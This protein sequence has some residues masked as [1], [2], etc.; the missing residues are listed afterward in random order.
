MKTIPPVVTPA[1]YRKYCEELHR[2]DFQKMSNN[3]DWVKL[4]IQQQKHSG[5]CR[6]VRNCYHKMIEYSNHTIR[7]IR[8]V[9]GREKVRKRWIRND[10]NS[11][12]MQLPSDIYS[13]YPHIQRKYKIRPAG[14][15]K[16]MKMV[17]IMQTDRAHI[18]VKMEVYQ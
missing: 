15:Y 18:L 8:L 2:L 10:L 4:L 12:L 16:M 3:L 1:I 7:V 17:Y 9:E 5:W 11:R 14:L 13:T 6:V